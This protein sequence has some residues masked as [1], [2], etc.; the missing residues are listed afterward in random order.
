MFAAF[1]HVHARAGFE[2]AFIEGRRFAGTT[3]AVEEGEPFV[4]R[5]EIELDDGWRTSVAR[6][7]SRSR[8]GARTALIEADGEGAW[9]VDG[10]P[11][12]ALAGCFDVDLE[13]SALTNAFPVNRLRLSPGESAEAPA[14]YVRA[15][16]LT[17]QRLEQRYVA[18]GDRRYRY[19]SPEF[20]FEC[21]LS[22]GDDGLVLDYPG[23]ARRHAAA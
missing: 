6:V 3:T 17:V 20:G 21:E 8:A 5:Y 7:W 4:V 18:L 1:E 10:E 13:S 12:P 19:T 11:A 16:D 14:A 9:R 22:Y 15:L 2:V 23:I